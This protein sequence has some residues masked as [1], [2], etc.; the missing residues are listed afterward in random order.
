MNAV[1][2]QMAIMD[3]EEANPLFRAPVEW[4]KEDGKVVGKVLDIGTGEGAWAMDVADEFGDGESYHRRKRKM[5]STWG[6]ALA[7]K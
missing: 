6:E 4:T 3:C 7:N 5:V 2:V 1:H